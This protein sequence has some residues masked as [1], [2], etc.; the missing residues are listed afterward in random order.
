MDTTAE[1]F[2]RLY[3]LEQ[4]A[5]AR[6]RERLRILLNERNEWRERAAILQMRLDLD[7]GKGVGSGEPGIETRRKKGGKKARMEKGNAAGACGKA[8]EERDHGEGLS[9]ELG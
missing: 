3:L 2:Q 1:D 9:G 7:R 8:G 5:H 4:Q 6:T